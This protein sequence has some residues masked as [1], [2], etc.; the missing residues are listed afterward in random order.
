MI[1]TINLNSYIKS[2]IEVFLFHSFKLVISYVVL[3][4]DM[5]NRS[6]YEVIAAM[7]RSCYRRESRT[8][9]MY[10]AMLSNDQCKLYLDSL[11]QYG[12]IQQVE[13]ND[14]MMYVITERGNKFLTFYEQMKNLLPNFIEVSEDYYGVQNEN[15]VLNSIA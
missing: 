5:K 8:K 1:T 9:I 11:L 6:R 7:L 14:K 13:F 15:K 12:L 3:E 2:S 4:M 10:K